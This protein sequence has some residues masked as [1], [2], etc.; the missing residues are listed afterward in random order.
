MSDETI[1]EQLT[2]MAC[3]S[4]ASNAY[5]EIRRFADGTTDEGKVRLIRMICDCFPPDHP[6]AKFGVIA[7][8]SKKEP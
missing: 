3:R 4:G 2:H 5:L 8:E 1:A 7:N 6:M